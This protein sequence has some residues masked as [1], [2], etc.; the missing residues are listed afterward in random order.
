MSEESA[1]FSGCF[2]G[3]GD[4]LGKWRLKCVWLSFCVDET[5][6]QCHV[7]SLKIMICCS[8][9]ALALEWSLSGYLLSVLCYFIYSLLVLGGSV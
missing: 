3:S 8:L 4:S 6:D 5:S 7:Q 9:F 2:Q 1:G